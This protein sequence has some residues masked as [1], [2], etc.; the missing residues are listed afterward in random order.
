MDKD[1]VFKEIEKMKDEMTQTLM[2]LVQ[3]P[4][5]APQSGGDGECKRAE[6]LIQILEMMGLTAS[7]HFYADDERVTSKKRPNIVTWV[8]GDSK[9]RLWIVTH[10]DMVPP[11]E[12][13][14][15]TAT[16]PFE[17]IVKDGK[18]YGRGTED[19]LQAMVSSIF[20]MKAVKK[21]GIKPK[22]TVALC[23][24]ADEENG[25][26]YGIQ[27]IIGKGIFRND[28]LVVVPDGG[29]SDGSFIE[30]AEKS[31]L[32]LK[33]STF[34]KQTH[35]SRPGDGLNANRV[36]MEY[37]LA[38]DR[39]LHQK[40]SA[41]DEYFDPP[42]S[43]F[44]PTRK[45]KNVDA[46][47]IVPGEDIFY[48]DCRILPRYDT[49]EVFKDIKTLAAAFEQ[50][51]GAKIAIEI[52]SKTTASKPTDSNARIVLMLK[53]ALETTRG[54]EPKIGGI[55]GG[56]CAAYFR[57]AGIPAVVWSTSDE[58]AHQPNEYSKI[59]N[60]IDDAKIFAQLATM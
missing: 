2:E 12:V 23:F 31:S 53:E 35:A 41:K 37:A 52:A 45:E 38:L 60:M 1:L 13:A 6:R 9:E 15:W 26:K 57:K 50:K 11:G 46:V 22:R 59:K 32:W 36:G 16:K 30:I 25:S 5:M 58:M 43:T 27:Y 10:L 49:D 42:E 48:F 20:A 56:T 21:L 19:N 24:V 54:I 47:N 28:D 39:M 40:Y 14:L 7:E 51:T 8:E 55:G 4:A 34:G 17:P 44:E 18:I 33:I 29:S 3:I